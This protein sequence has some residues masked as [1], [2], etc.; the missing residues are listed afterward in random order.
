MNE[1]WWQEWMIVWLL[2]RMNVWMNEWLRDWM[3]WMN[4]WLF[5]WIILSV[6]ELIDESIINRL[7]EWWWNELIH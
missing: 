3:G 5:D 1:W 2:E 7:N 6:N 4:E